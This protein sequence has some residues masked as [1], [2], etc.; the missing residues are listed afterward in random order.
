MGRVHPDTGGC[1]LGFPSCCFKSDASP[2]WLSPAKGAQ[3]PG[4]WHATAAGSI[5]VGQVEGEHGSWG[6][7]T[8]PSSTDQVVHREDS[9][10]SWEF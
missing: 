2:A 9:L 7:T 1:D 3:V 6:K 10:R 4:A 5:E 8:T